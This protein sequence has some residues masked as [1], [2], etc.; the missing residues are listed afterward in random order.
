[1]V[2]IWLTGGLI[3]LAGMLLTYL[4]KSRK[5]SAIPFR[6]HLHGNRRVLR[7]IRRL[8]RCKQ[9]YIR[10]LQASSTVLMSAIGE[11]AVIGNSRSASTPIVR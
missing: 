4:L 10:T 2:L 3:L 5:A 7:L 11:A 6:V 1:M 8:L 9:P